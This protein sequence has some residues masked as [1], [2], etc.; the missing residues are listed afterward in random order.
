M[1]ELGTAIRFAARDLRGGLRGFRV[2]LA[3]LALGVAAIAGIG[4]LTATVHEGIARDGRTLLGG[5]L[6]VRTS[7]RPASPAEIAWFRDHARLSAVAVMRAMAARADAPQRRA[8]IE[9]KAVDDAYPLLGRVALRPASNLQT[10]LAR[11]P[12]GRFGTAVEHALLARLGLKV[13]DVLRIGTATFRIRA[14][15]E[16]EPDKASGAFKL[17]P[18]VFI[19]AAALPATGLVQP[20]SLI[21]YGYR[22][23]AR[24]G[25]G[26]NAL[27]AALARAFPD[28]A[29]RVRT[30]DDAVPRIQRYI[31]RAALFFTLVG[32]IALLVGGIGVAGAV[33][34]HLEGKRDVI[35]TLKCLGARGRF[36]FLVF[37]LEIAVMAAIGIGIGLV[38]GAALP[39]AVAPLL[40]PYLPVAPGFALY[41]E[42]L[43]AAAAYGVAVAVLF[44]LWPLS[45]AREI[46]A[47]A[48][49]RGLVAE[50]RFR[51][52]A[53]TLAALV[54]AGGIVAALALGTA[55]RPGLAAWFV[56]GAVIAFA[57]FGLAG[58][59][60]RH[61][62]RAWATALSARGRP[63]PRLQLALGNIARPG[64][65]AQAIVLALG[66]GLT[67]FVTLAQ[68]EGNFQREITRHL[69]DSAPAYFFIDIQPDQVAAFERTV[70]AVPGTGAIDRLPSLRGRIV[71]VNGTPIDRIRVGPGARWAV[72]SDR[73]VT[74]AGA[75][76]KNTE[77]ET[78]SWWP[79]GYKGPPLLSI[80]ARVAKGLGAHVGD[81]VTIN[82]LGR[83][84]TARIANTRRIDWSQLGLNFVL[85]LSPGV[86]EDAPQTFI[87]TVKARP[88]AEDALARTVADR[89]PNVTAIGVREALQAVA[90][91]LEK[92]GAAARATAGLALVAGVLVLMG[93]IAAGR[94]ERTRDA[95]ILK[96]TG[97]RRRDL[98]AAYIIEYGLAGLAAGG[99]AAGLGTL[100]AFLV[101][102]RV[103]TADWV[104][105]PGPA[106]ATLLVAA[107]AVIGFGF[108]G[109]WHA[110]ARRPAAVLRETA[111]S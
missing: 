96:V 49:F 85:M 91:T 50:T 109:T 40:G 103:M 17:G 63:W 72:D 102:T 101:L 65:P 75:M 66:I 111:S 79:A 56:A 61:A 39:V 18:R 55:F 7:Q 16:S 41:P 92:I 90:D 2:M 54:A 106:A 97:A 27:A 31:D 6:A 110:L 37:G 99:I 32:L 71:K 8:L 93:A 86:L 87:A 59:A 57:V 12:G 81:T 52:R 47:A 107:L 14:E 51:P 95:V 13:G 5:D 29:W 100:A 68:I 35:A 11:G 60:L 67:V 46:P 24:R 10:L 88:G 83:D 84:V 53:G 25:E 42:A 43:A 62:A 15:V 58:V 48:L 94:R 4:S 33:A 78:G 64:A 74:Y 80:D 73:G 30:V 22:L 21:R 69:P 104:F 70:H 1:R 98:A 34:G 82:V 45:R 105:L 76:P 19:A 108:A 26:G 3:C 20:G 77:I 23:L 38:V 36:V 89:F 9:L 28:A 44:T